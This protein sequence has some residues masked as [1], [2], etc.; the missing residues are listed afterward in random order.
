MRFQSCTVWVATL[1]VVGAQSGPGATPAAA[2]S[3]RAPSIT[4]DMPPEV[5]SW[6][7]LV[8]TREQYG[9]LAAQ[10][11]AYVDA[12]PG[13][14]VA[15]VELS[16]AL[17]YA[18]GTP[19]EERNELIRTAYELDPNCP[20]A[21]EAVAN[22]CLTTKSPLA[23][24]RE[25]YALA[26]RACEL[27]PDWPEPHFTRWSLSILL[28]H[29]EDGQEELTALLEK[30][31]YAAPVLDFGY[32]MLASAVRGAIVFTN[33]DNDTYPP[34]SLQAAR[35]IRP[36]VLI[37]NLSLLNLPEYVEMVWD[38]LPQD[39][40]PFPKAEIQ[41]R[42][43]AWKQG[44]DTTNSF[45]DVVVE[46]LMKPVGSVGWRKGVYFAVTVNPQVLER[47]EGY[48]R[49]EGL[50]FR[51]TSEQL[52]VAEE[53]AAVDADRTLD[54]FRNTFRL[55]SATD[56]GYDWR[57]GNAAGLLVMNYVAV[58]RR[59]ATQKAE[60]GDLGDA[61]YAL[62]E[63]I[64]LADFHGDAEM[65]QELAAYWAEVEP[66]NAEVYGWLK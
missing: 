6:R 41:E 13:S 7:T 52:A 30:G 45:S 32:N 56:L 57:P 1:L 51:V 35:G 14:A 47:Y 18:G 65:V 60:A 23:T 31:A 46:A 42:H 22:T 55:D 63:A 44:E 4:A 34:L 9:D 11:Q 54:L 39:Q 21:L 5:E 59:V 10:W 38:R 26:S 28:G 36:D 50:L 8:L 25:A 16:R 62:R 15:Y 58:L 37:V 27:A 43:R 17:R 40:R 20:E 61:S 24:P 53:G 19:V 2:A 3:P 12:H 33:G 49:L 64:M 48:L 66:E 29:P